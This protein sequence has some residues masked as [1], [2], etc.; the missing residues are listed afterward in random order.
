MDTVDEDPVTNNNGSGSTRIP[1]SNTETLTGLLEAM[2]EF[3]SLSLEERQRLMMQILSVAIS[4]RGSFEQTVSGSKPG[5]GLSEQV[6]SEKLRTRAVVGDHESVCAVCLGQL[7]G[8]DKNETV[9]AK[10]EICGHEYHVD[11]IKEWLQRKNLCPLCRG[12]ALEVDH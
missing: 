10:L 9:I 7:C 11:C 12:I 6:I 3:M 8:S 1:T 5:N 4:G 2:R